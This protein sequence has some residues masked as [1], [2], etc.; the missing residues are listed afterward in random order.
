[1]TADSDELAQLGERYALLNPTGFVATKLDETTRAAALVGLSQ[2][3]RL[4]L[5]YVCAGPLVPDDI[6]LATPDLL[7]EL[8]I[9]AWVR[10]R[11]GVLT[12]A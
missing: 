9:A 2:R 10:R 3:L 4:P 1:M 5:H 6:S 8:L 12:R 7:A 11:S